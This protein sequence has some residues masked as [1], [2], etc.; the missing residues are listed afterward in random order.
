MRPNVHLIFNP[1]SGQ[2]NAELDLAQVRSHLEP[3]FELTVFETSPE[4]DANTLAAQSVEQGVDLVVVSGGDGT[5]NAA[6]EAMIQSPVPLAII[7]R[8]TANAVA[9][10]LGISTDLDQACQV[11]LDGDVRDVDTARCNGRPMVL[12][13]G[14]GLEADVIENVPRERKDRLGVLAYIMAGLQQLSD[15]PS[16]DVTLE[17]KD[18]VISVQAAAITVANMAPPTSILAQGPARVSADDGLL[19]IT[20]FAPAGVGSTIAA[21]YELLRSAMS[22]EATQRDDVGFIRSE[23]VTIA[24]D[25]PQKV[26]LDGELCGETPVEVVCVPKGLRLVVPKHALINKSEDLE[27]LPGLEVEYKQGTAATELP[28]N[29][30][31][32]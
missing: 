5:I 4:R 27:G 12:L 17:T 16:F 28:L 29:K 13:A 18:K 31:G 21:S 2:G 1:V 23:S 3:A 7:P 8:G 24:T 32:Q 15:L 14:I 22:G 26:V 6:A 10:C 11:I 20:I 25:P 9:S 19:D 30:L